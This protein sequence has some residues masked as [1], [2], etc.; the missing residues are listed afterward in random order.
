MDDMEYKVDEGVRSE[1]GQLYYV[2]F[3][4]GD[5]KKVLEHLKQ[6]TIEKPT[7]PGQCGDGQAMAMLMSLRE[8]E[9]NIVRFIESMIKI[10][11]REEAHERSTR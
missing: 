10:G 1:I 2:L 5:G 3:S 7:M 6:R 11:E 9:N 4:R 8:G